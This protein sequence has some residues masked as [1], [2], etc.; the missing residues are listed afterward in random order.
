MVHRNW[1]ILKKKPLSNLRIANK[2][3]HLVL[4]RYYELAFSNAL[5]D[6][7][8]TETTST[9]SSGYFA[10]FSLAIAQLNRKSV[11]WNQPEL[12]IPDADQKDQSSGIRMSGPKSGRE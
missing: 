7:T 11:N 4:A 12:L 10:F 9:P 1:R 5:N 8:K 6:I 2:T 3:W